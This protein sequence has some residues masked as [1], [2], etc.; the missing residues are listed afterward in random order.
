MK[1]LCSHRDSFI[2]NIPSLTQNDR[3]ATLKDGAVDSKAGRG[4]ARSGP[5]LHPGYGRIAG[6]NRV[7]AGAYSSDVRAATNFR[8]A[9]KS[10]IGLGC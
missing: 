9:E 2:L 1:R 7:G 4:N 10:R 8:G 5:E 3:P 6:L